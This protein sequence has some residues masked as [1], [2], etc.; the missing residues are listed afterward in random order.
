MRE[1]SK[2][3]GVLVEQAGVANRVTFVIDMDGKITDIFE[4]AA[5]LD[6]S[7]AE[8]ACSRLKKH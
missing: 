5:A 2:T 8:T 4:N 1:V 7:G 6:P 3:Y